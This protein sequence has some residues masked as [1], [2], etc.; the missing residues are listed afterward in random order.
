MPSYKVISADTHVV[1]PPEVYASIDRK[2]YGVN[3]I[4]TVVRKTDQHGDPY[5]G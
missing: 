4:P 5:G 1:E 3:R 2:K